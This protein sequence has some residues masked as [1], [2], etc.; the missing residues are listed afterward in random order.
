MNSGIG[1]VPIALAIWALVFLVFRVIVLWYWKVNQVVALLKS[2][3]AK[4]G[5]MLPKER[6][7]D[8]RL[9]DIDSL[10]ISRE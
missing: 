7:D 4:L 5:R 1:P 2:I 6:L 8:I 3:D 10:T 9:G